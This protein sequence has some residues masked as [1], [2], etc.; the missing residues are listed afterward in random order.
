MDEGIKMDDPATVSRK[1]AGDFDDY[2]C[3][4]SWKTI[5]QTER[6]MAKRDRR[7]HQRLQDRC[8]ETSSSIQSCIF[9]S[10]L[11]TGRSGGSKK[12][13]KKYSTSLANEQIQSLEQARHS[14]LLS[15]IFP[16]HLCCK[17]FFF[18]SGFLLKTVSWAKQAT[19][20]WSVRQWI[21]YI[22]ED[23]L[24]SCCSVQ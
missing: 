19:G 4:S 16:L 5:L 13:T 7:T 6:V 23:S 20:P 22:P 15:S 18:F 11:L 1:A 12:Q 21:Q 24:E 14:V 2:A 17:P 8:Y 10:L 3:Q 9:F